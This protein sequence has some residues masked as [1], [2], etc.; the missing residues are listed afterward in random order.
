MPPKKKQSG[1]TPVKGTMEDGETATGETSHSPGQ[2]E[3][4]QGLWSA[5]TG[6]TS[7]SG[8]VTERHSQG[9]NPAMVRVFIKLSEDGTNW[10]AWLTALKAAADG[11]RARFALDQ[12]QPDTPEDS[13]I[14][15]MLFESIPDIWMGEVANK[16]S[17]YEAVHWL[18]AKFVGGKNEQSTNRWLRELNGGLDQESH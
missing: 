5:R 7:T 6:E 9:V 4:S 11:K 12:P 15:M 14:R 16:D 2:L 18:L 13:A 3:G 17:A 1:S 8:R 10:K